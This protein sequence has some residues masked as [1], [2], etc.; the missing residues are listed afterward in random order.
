LL[1]ANNPSSRAPCP[2]FQ[3]IKNGIKGICGPVFI[4]T[5]MTKTKASK[6]AEDGERQRK[7]EVPSKLKAN[8]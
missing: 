8:K 3:D 5:N 6:E 2:G 4:H 7:G 1:D